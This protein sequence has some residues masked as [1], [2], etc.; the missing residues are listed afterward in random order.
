MICKNISLFFKLVEIA[1]RFHKYELV[2]VAYSNASITTGSKWLSPLVW[3]GVGF[4]SIVMG[5]AITAG[6]KTDG[7]VR[8]ITADL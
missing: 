3:G 7:D 5:G 4:K 1:S 6:S 2:I 8:H